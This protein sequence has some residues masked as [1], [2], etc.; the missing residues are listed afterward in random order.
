MDSWKGSSLESTTYVTTV[1]ELG[2]LIKSI[3]SV[4]S[5]PVSV[6]G[7][8]S[9]VVTGGAS[10]KMKKAIK[11]AKDWTTS[12]INSLVKSFLIDQ[13]G[14]LIGESSEIEITIHHFAVL[15]KAASAL[16]TISPFFK[17]ESGALEIKLIDANESDYTG[18][19]I[20][21]DMSVYESSGY[22]YLTVSIGPVLQNVQVDLNLV[23]TDGYTQSE[24]KYTDSYGEV[25]FQVPSG[26]SG[27]K[28]TATVSLPGSNF[29]KEFAWTY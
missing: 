17:E 21:E 6:A 24:T 2:E 7:N 4:S 10:L 15:S 25:T 29:S 28:D 5:L 22:A 27:V 11:I 1:G 8:I 14:K 16:S 18:D 26:V 12:K 3:M 20:I 23:G 13:T 19:P 9:L